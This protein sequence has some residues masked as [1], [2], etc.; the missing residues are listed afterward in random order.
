MGNL[1]PEERQRLINERS[2]SIELI[3][4]KINVINLF[5][6]TNLYFQ[7]GSKFYFNS[8]KSIQ[9]SLQRKDQLLKDYELDLAKLRQAEFLLE[10][11]SDQLDDVQ[12][13]FNLF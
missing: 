13:N 12:V 2:K 5:L 4:N 9:E 6:L 10:K 8:L 3:C 1:P 7:N 11:K